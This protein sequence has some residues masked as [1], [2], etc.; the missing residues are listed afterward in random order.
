MAVIKPTLTL[1]S[2]SSSATTDAGPLSVALSLSATDSLTVDTVEAATITPTTTVSTLFDGSTKDIGSEVAGTN[3]GFIYFKNTSA[4]D[5]DVY[6]G[7]EAHS[8]SAT[9]LQANADAQRLFTLKQG[10]FAFFPYDY[11][12]DI[13]VDAE[14]AAATLEYFLFNRAI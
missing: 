10:E 2:N 5:H 7:I 11:N 9:E 4:A 14:N 13:T 8:A 12:M 3:G 1:T 6:I